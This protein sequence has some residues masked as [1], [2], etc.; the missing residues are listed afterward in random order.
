MT[1]ITQSP[2]WKELRD[3]YG[4]IERASS[5]NSF[6]GGGPVT[7]LDQSAIDMATASKNSPD[8]PETSDYWRDGADSGPGAGPRSYPGANPRR[9]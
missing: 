6:D 3:H 7:N 9:S 4:Q 5:A 1:P 2:E 8:V